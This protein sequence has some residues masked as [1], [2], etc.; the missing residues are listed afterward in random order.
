MS[1]DGTYIAAGSRD[2]QVRI[3]RFNSGE[4]LHTLTAYPC[5]SDNLDFTLDGQR[6]A[7]AYQNGAVVLW[8]VTTGEQIRHLIDEQ[9]I[10]PGASDRCQNNDNQ[11]DA[12]R[13]TTLSISPDTAFVAAG[14]RWQILI[15]HVPTGE[16][17]CRIVVERTTI[18]DSTFTADSRTL[19]GGN[20]R[21]TIYLWDVASCQTT[22]I[23]EPPIYGDTDFI[24]GLMPLP[25]SDTFILVRVQNADVE[26]WS[27][28][29]QRL[30]QQDAIPRRSG[31]WAFTD[32]GELFARGGPGSYGFFANSGLP[33]WGGRDDPNIYVGRLTGVIGTSNDIT[34]YTALQGHTDGVTSLAFS[35]DGRLLVSGSKDGTV[36]LWRV[37]AFEE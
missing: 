11:L 19:I 22:A 12:R 13:I 23:L 25:N 28:Q 9:P 5:F 7:V 1:N 37:P 14:S 8:D 4:L 17:Q 32:N 15:S 34:S 20:T 36:R 6:L 26:V 27:M 10:R 29:G 31:A 30:S 35:G 33:F 16:I 21:G 24:R 3:W 18:W 2:N